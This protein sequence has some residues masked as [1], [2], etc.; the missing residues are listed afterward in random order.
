MAFDLNPATLNAVGSGLTIAGH[1]SA[2]SAARAAGRAQREAANYSAA[3]LEANAGQ[4]QAAAQRAAAEEIRKSIMLQSRAVAIAAASGGGAVDPT[5]LALIAGVAGE[6]QLAAETQIYNGDE[7]ARQLREQAKATRYEGELRGAAG[8]IASR[9]ALLSIGGT[10]LSG[11]S[12]DW[13]GAGKIPAGR[14]P[15]SESVTKY[16]R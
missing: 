9:N 10:I 4:Q 16:I 8:E 6:G 13:Y 5:V 2:S 15:V 14:A 1:L 3:Q 7:R 11:M 12:K